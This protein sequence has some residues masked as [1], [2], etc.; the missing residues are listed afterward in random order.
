MRTYTTVESAPYCCFAA[1]LEA[2]FRRNGINHISQYDIANYL[3]LVVYE[4]EK[5]EIPQ[6][7]TNVSYSSDSRI[8]GLH[9]A[10]D[11]LAK[12]FHH[13]NLPFKEDYI[14][15]Q[16]ISD[17]NFEYLLKSISNEYDVILYFD[18]G[19]LYR[20]E[21]N[22]GVGH[23]GLLIDVDDNSQVTYLNPGPRHLGLNIFTAADFLDAIKARKG[24]LSIIHK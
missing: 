10:D 5:D 4:N 13:F 20:E 17:W 7:L 19:R 11:T 2:I 8:I 14:S 23:V 16:Q 18:F 24:G 1:S 3:G 9:I 15:W 6:A 22:V 12:L 21:E